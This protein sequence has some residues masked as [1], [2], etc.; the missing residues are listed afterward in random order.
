[1]TYLTNTKMY[2]YVINNTGETSIKGKL[3]QNDSTTGQVILTTNDSFE[4]VGVIDEAGVAN[5]STMRIITGGETAVLLEDNVGST[6]GYWAGAGDSGYAE[7]AAAAPG[8]VLQHFREIGHFS[9]T[10]AA[11]GVGTHVLAK[12]IMHFN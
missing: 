8:L 5:G 7:V 11:G 9:E 12:L 6:A 2:Q 4:C 1:M 3:V 10:V